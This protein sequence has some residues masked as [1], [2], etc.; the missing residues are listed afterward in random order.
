MSETTNPTTATTA[1]ATESATTARGP[2]LL[3]LGIAVGILAAG[4]LLTALTSDVIKVSEPGIA[5]VN[6]E[7]YLPAR[8]GDWEGGPQEGLSEVE[9]NVL[10]KDTLGARRVYRDKAGNQLYCSIVLAGRD[11]T[12]IHRPEVCLPGQGWRIQ[13]QYVQTVPVPA[14]P[15]G[16]LGI[17]RM[18]SVREAQ[19]APGGPTVPVY[20]VFAYWFVGKDVLTPHHWERILLNTWDRVFHNTNH[21]WAYILIHVPVKPENAVQLPNYG[22]DD[23]MQTVANFVKELFPALA[24]PAS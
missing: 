4:V 9:R 18:N 3:H 5:L 22:T 8:V 14:A 20:S 7:P 21:R 2:G 6:N 17:M 10:P 12:S 1:P 11:V 15:G 16:K 23:A 24:T 13:S 19:T